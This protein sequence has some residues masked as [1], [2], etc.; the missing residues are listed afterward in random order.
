[1]H[2]THFSTNYLIKKYSRFR[3]EILIISKQYYKKIIKVILKGLIPFF[4]TC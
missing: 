4:S 2:D 3:I 1:M